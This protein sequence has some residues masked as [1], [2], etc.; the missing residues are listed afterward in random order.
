MHTNIFFH[1]V[2]IF[3]IALLLFFTFTVKKESAPQTSHQDIKPSCHIS[4][5]TPQPSVFHSEI[6]NTYRNLP[7]KKS[8]NALLVAREDNKVLSPSILFPHLSWEQ[9]MEIYYAGRPAV[10]VRYPN[11]LDYQGITQLSDTVYSIDI[12]PFI[13]QSENPELL[14]QI[15]IDDSTNTILLTEIVPGSIYDRMGI[16]SGDQ[17]IKIN[18]RSVNGYPDLYHNYTELHEKSVINITVLRNN[19]PI[20][21]TYFLE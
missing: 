4:E 14:N 13:S 15:K 20:E 16:H 8:N 6:N 3:S 1:M 18:E 7:V 19:Q 5:S 9:K 2:A 11:G 21:F 10:A 12:H 17:L